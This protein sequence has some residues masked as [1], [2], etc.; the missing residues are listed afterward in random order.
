MNRLVPVEQRPVVRQPRLRH[1]P[2]YDGSAENLATTNVP[3]DQ[4]PLTGGTA[5]AVIPFGDTSL[6]LVAR[7]HD[8][9]GSP[10][11]AARPWILLVGGLLLTAVAAFAVGLVIRGRRRAERDGRTIGD[12]YDRLEHLYAEQRGIAETL[13]RSLLPA[14]NPDVRNLEIGS[15]YVA[16]GKGVEIGGDWYSI[17]PLDEKHYGFVVGDVSGHGVDAASVM[18]RLRFTIRAYLAEGHAPDVALD[19]CARQFDV[20][21]DGH[22]ATVLVGVGDVVTGELVLSSA[23]HFAPLVVHAGR[24]EYVRCEQSP[25]L[26]TSTKQH[27]AT[28]VVLEP[29][30]TVLMFTDGLIERRTESLDVGLERLA[31]SAVGSEGSPDDLL[32][33]VLGDVDGDPEDDIAL[34]AFR[35]EPDTVVTADP[36]V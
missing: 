29:G 30:S 8:Q 12:L 23:G 31:S 3:L 27:T 28:T 7:P 2:R 33:A 13:Q 15:R 11:A 19:L 10:S 34:L 24:A 26:G 6:T 5:S 14:F 18:A 32:D 17:I 1:L 4:L 25:P 20:V 22:F 36:P 35:W 21:R 16:G 9:L